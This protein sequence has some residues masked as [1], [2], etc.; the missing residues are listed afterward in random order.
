MPV[1]GHVL[2]TLL[3]SKILDLFAVRE[4]ARCVA[5]G[6][7]ML[8][9]LVLQFAWL[10]LAVSAGFP[11]AAQPL[12]AVVGLEDCDQQIDLELSI[13]ACS[14]IINHDARPTRVAWAYFNRLA[15]P[16]DAL[17]LRCVE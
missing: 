10:L 11:V 6:A 4:M 17:L 12:S 14:E 2:S 3:W 5:L 7:R 8:R 13:R 16:V 1:T 9:R 15:S